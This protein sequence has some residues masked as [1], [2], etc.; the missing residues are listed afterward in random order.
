AYRVAALVTSNL[1]RIPRGRFAPSIGRP[2]FIDPLWLIKKPIPRVLS[3]NLA[4][5]KLGNADRS[6]ALMSP[7]FYVCNQALGCTPCGLRCFAS[8]SASP[9]ASPWGRWLL[10]PT[11][12]TLDL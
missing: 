6:G 12:R 10:I 3:A 7:D 9:S 1:S 5:K 8:S 2:E 11:K 4:S